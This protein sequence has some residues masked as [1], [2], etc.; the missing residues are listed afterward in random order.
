[1]QQQIGEIQHEIRRNLPNGNLPEFF[2][3]EKRLGKRERKGHTVF[4]SEGG[5]QQ[6]EQDSS[7]GV[8][9]VTTPTANVSTPPDSTCIT[10]I[11]YRQG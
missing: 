2:G 3:T 6:K 9:I 11:R 7:R 5:E 8:D 10:H 1:M 4:D